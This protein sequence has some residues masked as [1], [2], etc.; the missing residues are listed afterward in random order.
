MNMSTMFS[1]NGIL[2]P[3][4]RKASP[5]RALTPSTARLA[6]NRPAGTPNCGQDAMKPRCALVFA[7]SIARRTDPPHS[8]PTPTP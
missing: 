5:D 3:H 1:R 7:H 4:S 2:Q 8:P 6:R